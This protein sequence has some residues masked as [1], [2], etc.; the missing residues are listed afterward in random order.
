MSDTDHHPED[1]ARDFVSLERLRRKRTWQPTLEDGSLT[2]LGGHLEQFA[3]GL[4]EQERKA[5]SAMLRMSP[6]DQAL[7][8]LGAEPPESI[9][10]IEE[11]KIFEALRTK[12]AGARRSLEPALVLIMK[13]TRYCNLRCSYCGTWRDGP[14][15]RMSFEV[16]ARSIHGALS[17][18]EVRGVEFFWHGGEPTL[19]PVSFYRSA[20][21]MQQ[22]FRRPGQAVA[23]TLQ[24]NGTRLT[25]EWLEFL[26]R[27]RFRVEVSLD[28]PPEIHDRWRIDTAGRPTSQRVRQG[29]DTLREHGL[30]P[31]AIMVVGDD[32]MALGAERLLNYFLEIGVTNVGLQNLVPEGDG[33]GASLEERY[34]EYARFVEFLRELFH[35]WWPDHTERIAFREISDLVSRIRGKPA[36]LCL[37]NENCMGNILTI[38]PMGDLTAC[39]KYQ[40]DPAYRF[41]NVLE[42]DFADFPASPEFIRAHAEVAA[43]V[44]QGA[45]SCPWSSICHTGCP[46]NWYVR[47]QLGASHHQRCCGLAPL[48]SDIAEAVGKRSIHQG[49]PG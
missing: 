38:E 4:T 6:R 45:G 49:R 34:I 43:Q 44:Q 19:L 20:L 46:F 31:A 24:T 2:S 39:D 7:V 40:S 13:A 32:V 37:Y 9:L 29:L 11:R 23:N 33:R 5:L 10:D 12:P 18:P 22:Q 21:W 14:N 1:P 8:A 41:G 36:G 27:Y 15:Q 35:L 28:G 16:L 25:P 42:T 26:K 47:T 48:L 30:D 3:E 17:A